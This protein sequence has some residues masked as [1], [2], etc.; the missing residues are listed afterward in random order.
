MLSMI[1]YIRHLFIKNIH[2]KKQYA[3]RFVFKTCVKKVVQIAR[4]EL[5]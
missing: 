2:Q 1:E 3:L 4:F 5:A